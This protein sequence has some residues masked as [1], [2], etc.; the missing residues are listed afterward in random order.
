M[1]LLVIIIILSESF[2]LWYLNH[3]MNIPIDR[4]SAANYV[5]QFSIVTFCLNVIRV[6]FN[7]SI[8]AYEKMNFY[9]YVSIFET[10]LKLLIV[11]LLLIGNFD[12]LILYGFLLMLVTFW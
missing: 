9:A 4:Q 1:V 7:A 3:I 8:I 5:Y 6:P 2:G 10:V 12:K 11:Y